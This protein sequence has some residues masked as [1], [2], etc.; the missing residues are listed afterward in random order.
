MK[1]RECSLCHLS[2][3]SKGPVWG[4]GDPQARLWW[5]G[6]APGREEDLKGRPFV[7]MAGKESENYKA[8]YGIRAIPQYTTNVVKCRPPKNRDP[9][10]VEIE[11]CSYHLEQEYDLI[12]PDA[13]VGAL[14]RFAAQIFLGELPEMD[15]IHS[16]PFR[17][18]RGWSVIPIY[19]PAAGMYPGG[20]RLMTFIDQGYKAVADALEGRI[21]P[22]D[23]HDP[24]PN[25]KYEL[26]QGQTLKIPKQIGLDTESIRD[27]IWSIQF[28]TTPGTGLFVRQDNTPGLELLR[29]WAESGVTF[30]MHNAQ[31]DLAMLAQVGIHPKKWVDTMLM[32][33][34]LCDVP[35]GLKALAY[36]LCGMKMKSYHDLVFPIND[37]K[38]IEYLEEV[39][40]I[41]WPDPDPV[42]KIEKGI[43]KATHPQ[44]LHKRVRRIL[45]DVFNQKCTSPYERWLKQPLEM[46]DM[47]EHFLGQF[48]ESTIA[49]VEFDKALYYSC[50][51][52]DATLRVYPKLAARI[53]AYGLQEPL[54]LDHG[55]VPILSEMEETGFKVD[56]DRLR[57]VSDDMANLKERMLCQI[58][59]IA[60]KWV[61]PG[62]QDQVGHLLYKQLRIKPPRRQKGQSKPGTDKEN[63]GKIKTA[64]PVVPRILTYRAADKIKGSFSDRLLRMVDENNRVHDDLSQIRTT[65]GRLTSSIMLLIPKRGEYAP[66]LRRCFVAKDDCVYLSADFSQIELRVL[67]HMSQD[68]LMIKTYQEDGDIHMATACNI[69][70]LPPDKIDKVNHRIPAKTVNFGIVYGLTEDGL[71]RQ[72]AQHGWSLEDCI[73]LIRDWIKLY[74][75]VKD[76]M[77]AFWHHARR[78]GFIAGMSGRRRLIPEVRSYFPHIRERGKREAGNHPIQT[79]ANDIMKK[80]MGRLYPVFKDLAKRFYL[81]ALLQLHDDLKVEVDTETKHLAQ[82]ATAMKTIMESTGKLSI[83]TPV[84]MEVGV[85]LGDMEEF[86]LK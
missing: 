38:I 59:D 64:H 78:Y 68:P 42:Y 67:A 86:E 66:E 65:S 48:H 33:N 41:E 31:F 2:S 71:H 72:L 14:G 36:R 70:G 15:M 10:P 54:E 61:N 9:K 3:Q 69:F 85:N 4:F 83:P 74:K 29:A 12:P 40:E 56:L 57:K 24:Y 43:R 51:D 28:S 11:A 58:K 76:L 8:R 7:G 47:A 63:L 53:E 62:S 84:D 1:K 44:A 77:D 39:A 22:E 6:E 16:I 13:V 45:K 50:R 46:R 18:E 55:I 32:A 30:I 73:K 26:Y 79:S 34:L 19:H 82:V 60:G 5:C 35:R 17:H 20:G 75:G 27:R 23:W 80:A 81:K 21:K 52:P 49:D 37:E 25:P